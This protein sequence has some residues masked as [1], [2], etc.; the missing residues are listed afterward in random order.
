MASRFPYVSP[1]KNLDVGTLSFTGGDF[2]KVYLFFRVVR[3]CIIAKEVFRHG[4]KYGN[5]N[6]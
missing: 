5:H 2:S 3:S 1:T 6:T 4:N